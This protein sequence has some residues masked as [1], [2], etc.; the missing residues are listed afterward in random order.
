[1]RSHDSRPTSDVDCGKSTRQELEAMDE[2]R[3]QPLDGGADRAAP[4]SERPRQ[5]E[6]IADRHRHEGAAG[7]ELSLALIR[8]GADHGDADT[9]AGEA[10]REALRRHLGPAHG[11]APRRR[12]R[13]DEGHTQRYRPRRA[14]SSS[15]LVA[16]VTVTIAA[17]Y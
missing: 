5:L 16:Y 14:E 15:L 12:E 10:S 17:V 2:I 7:L 4:A 1:V 13:A 11:R 9:A 3:L 6:A 8:P